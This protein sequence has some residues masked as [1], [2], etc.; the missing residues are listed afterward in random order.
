M[1][2][3]RFASNLED[4]VRVQDSK[5]AMAGKRIQVVLFKFVTGSSDVALQ[6][7]PSIAGRVRKNRH[8]RMSMEEIFRS[9]VMGKAGHHQDEHGKDLSSVRQWPRWSLS[10]SFRWENRSNEIRRWDETV[11]P[12][13]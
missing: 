7:L 3:R 9:V 4:A 13:G 5:L 10:G 2:G 11:G 8:L 6:R 12:W 1:D